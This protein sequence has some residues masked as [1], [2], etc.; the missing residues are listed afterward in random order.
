[1]ENIHSHCHHFSH[2][3]R[4]TTY[5]N[6]DNSLLAKAVFRNAHFLESSYEYF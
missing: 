4:R 2:L 1:M 6:S 3:T 5:A